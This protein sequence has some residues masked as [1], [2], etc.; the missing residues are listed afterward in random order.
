MMVKRL[1]KRKSGEEPILAKTTLNLALKSLQQIVNDFENTKIEYKKTKSELE[2]CVSE[3]DKYKDDCIVVTKAKE[4]HE[5][6][7]QIYK[8]DIE[9]QEAKI[10]ELEKKLQQISENSQLKQHEIELERKNTEER[11]HNIEDENFDL[12]R[13]IEEEK[14][15]NTEFRTTAE[16]SSSK[17]ECL[18]NALKEQKNHCNLMKN[19]LV[20][21][22]KEKEDIDEEH[23]KMKTLLSQQDTHMEELRNKINRLEGQLFNKNIAASLDSEHQ[24]GFR[25]ASLQHQNIVNHQL[26]TLSKENSTLTEKILLCQQYYNE[27]QKKC[28][29]RECKLLHKVEQLKHE[30]DIKE[31]ECIALE[32]ECK[33]MENECKT[34]ENEFKI[35]ENEFKKSSNMVTKKLIQKN[36]IASSSSAGPMSCEEHFLES[37]HELNSI[38]KDLKNRSQYQR[39]YLLDMKSRKIE[40]EKYEKG[41]VF[42]THKMNIVSIENDERKA[43]LNRLYKLQK[44]NSR[45]ADE[46]KDVLADIDVCRTENSELAKKIREQEET[47]KLLD[48]RVL[49][50]D[51]RRE[52]NTKL[53]ERMKSYKDK[54]DKL[55]EE[56]DAKEMFKKQAEM[57]KEEVNKTNTKSKV[58]KK[59]NKSLHEMVAKLNKDIDYLR[60]SSMKFGNTSCCMEL[61]VKL[62]FMEKQNKEQKKNN[63][64]LREQLK[65]S[66]KCEE[67]IRWIEQS[68]KD[69]EH[70]L[71]KSLKELE[72]NKDKLKGYESKMKIQEQETK[73]FEQPNVNV[74]VHLDSQ[75]ILDSETRKEQQHHHSTTNEDDKINEN[76]THSTQ[77]VSNQFDKNNKLCQQKQVTQTEYNK[78]DEQVP[79]KERCSTHTA[80]ADEKQGVKINEKEF[81]VDLKSK[82]VE[83]KELESLLEESKAKISSL[84]ESEQEMKHLI[85]DTKQDLTRIQNDNK[86][87]DE[88]HQ[89]EIEELRK[90]VSLMETEITESLVSQEIKAKEGETERQIKITNLE[91]ELQTLKEE[92]MKKNKR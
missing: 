46:S 35:M 60:K 91:K 48:E 15:I 1:L 10:C 39:E 18:K 53:V 41:E 44:D 26:S 40:G 9:V 32:D 12:K 57:L 5:I 62:E 75:K 33:T 58:L 80:R 28:E 89:I 14:E 30:L 17:T 7:V 81:R 49:E 43:L 88:E 11:L 4:S 78:T 74:H 22:T 92:Q 83:I 2:Q 82:Q 8:K 29:K 63:N 37:K 67:K 54:L 21:M 6:Q 34:M 19:K 27:L 90:K 79:D 23:Q 20:V 36:V 52:E 70:E 73:P 77:V 69:R 87:K 76:K 24:E 42:T 72:E 68:L 85:E 13:Q 47:I 56:I 55:Q 86:M 59:E 71:S 61:K 51:V 31:N 50:K 38:L 65:Q 84:E 66:A 64:A 45:L 3:F 25:E 16:K